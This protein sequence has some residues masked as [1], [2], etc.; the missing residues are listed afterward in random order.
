[1]PRPMGP[2]KKIEKSKD[3]KGSMKK[4]LKSLS[5]WYI[6]LRVSLTLAMISA[7]LA[8]IA[9]NKLSDLTNYI[10]EGITPRINETKIQEIIT[11]PSIPLED[12][13]KMSDIMSKMDKTSND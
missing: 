9:P 13:Q 2:G 4:I 3:F 6:A 8:L 5:S 12:K 1:M 10:T 7:I 11:D